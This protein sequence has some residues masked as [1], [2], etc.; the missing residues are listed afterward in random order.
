MV[1]LEIRLESARCIG[2]FPKL[3]P[4]LF[5]IVLFHVSLHGSLGFLDLAE[6]A[7]PVIEFEHIPS[8]DG[9]PVA[10]AGAGALHLIRQKFLVELHDA[11]L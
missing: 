5:G 4:A 10:V 8:N 3:R 1:V 9:S 7:S 11:L 6:L 2:E